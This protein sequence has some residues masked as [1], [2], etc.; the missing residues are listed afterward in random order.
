MINLTQYITEF[1][2]LILLG[3]SGFFFR[4]YELQKVAEDL[5]LQEC[6]SQTRKHKHLMESSLN[7]IYIF[8][9]D[10]FNFLEVNQA[11]KDNLGYSMEEMLSRTPLSIKPSMTA[12]VFYDLIA[13][14]LNM[15]LELV[16][17]STVHQRKNGSQ[18][19]V[20]VYLQLMP[21]E[22][23]SFLA[24]ILDISEKKQAEEELRASERKLKEA[25][26]ISHIGHW[27]LD[28]FNN[29]LQWSDEIYRIFNL[30]PQQFEA[31]YDAF[32]N[33]I[34]PEDRDMVND[35]YIQSLQEKKP[36]EI[37]HRLLLSDG[38]IKFV[39]EQCITKY[40]E[41]GAPVFSTGT[42]QDI[43]DNMLA[44]EELH[45]YRL[46]LE[47]MVESRT[48]DL[49]VANNDLVDFA[50]SVSHDLKAP[51]RAISGFSEIISRRHRDSLNDESKR[52][53]DH[54]LNASISMNQL[55][56]D[57]LK[58]SRL[59]RQAVEVKPVDLVEVFLV[60]ETTF[61]SRIDKLEASLTIPHSMPTVLG[62]KTLLIQ[63]FTNLI[64]NALSYRKTDAAPDVG[65]FFRIENDQVRI[66]V[67]DNGIG[68][69][70][71]FQEKVFN[72]FQRLHSEAEKPGTGIGL[73][74]VRKATSII[75]GSVEL[76]STVGE[77]SNFQ[78]VLQLEKQE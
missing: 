11:A 30:E 6:R 66:S 50:Y 69:A 40:D 41:Q 43:T 2:I 9:A 78:V 10:G 22:T 57:L 37:T 44:Q 76:E 60:L 24:I 45:R 1:G 61:G 21:G 70:P 48:A 62:D 4:R 18:Y 8:D 75:G 5:K 72:I 33:N 53:F 71:E 55:I 36:Y 12:S 31:T 35:A 25:Q 34:H 42:V 39:Q 52:Y 63:I 23:P 32:L 51:L 19:P 3:I 67:K 68:I 46:H 29:K 56:E 77:G 26:A 17:F 47:E 28:I 65:V 7:E 54:I 74:I 27:D 38:S 20:D 58:Y 13:P 16:Q 59:G 64:D 49:M 73:A 15:Q 14:L